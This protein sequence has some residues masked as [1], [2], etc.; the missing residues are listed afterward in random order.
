MAKNHIQQG[1]SMPYTNG[2]GTAIAS[3]TPI[4][5]GVLLCIALGNIAA[6]EEGQVATEEV[7]EVPK[8]APLV[9]AQGDQLYWDDA[10]GVV[11]KTDTDVPCGKAFAAA[12]SAA[13]TVQIK[14]NV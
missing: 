10:N 11:T 6:G 9:I 13:T 14:I 8:E 4:L 2:G 3:G 12:G 1:Q 5:I 7:W